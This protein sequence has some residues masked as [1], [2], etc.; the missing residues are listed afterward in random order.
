MAASTRA[1][2]HLERNLQPQHQVRFASG[3]LLDRLKKLTG[4]SRDEASVIERYF[5]QL[6]MKLIVS[7]RPCMPAPVLP[8]WV[9]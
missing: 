2:M 5:L 3:A 4:F 7:V 9:S 1:W 6:S 8:V